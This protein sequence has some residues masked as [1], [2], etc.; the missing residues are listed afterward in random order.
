MET[1]E[2]LNSHFVLLGV[3]NCVLMSR[4]EPLMIQRFGCLDPLARILSQHF[5]YQVF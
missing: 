5:L 3:R 1:F 4:L 2:P